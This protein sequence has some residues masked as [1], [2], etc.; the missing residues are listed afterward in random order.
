M[1]SL[2]N[3]KEAKALIKKKFPKFKD[4]DWNNHINLG[5]IKASKTEKVG[6]AKRYSYSTAEVNKFIE[7]WAQK[8]QG[9][10]AK[11]SNPKATK[12]VVNRISKNEVVE[13]AIP[14]SFL[15]KY[16]LGY[17]QERITQYVEKNLATILKE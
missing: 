5:T 3:S 14:S 10:V 17:L 6:K 1:A 2:L 13:I 4:Y 11:P 12:K 15:E 8:S 9:R 7:Y 16:Q